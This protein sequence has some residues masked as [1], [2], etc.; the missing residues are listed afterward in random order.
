[1]HD[2]SFITN[3]K[4]WVIKIG[5]ALLAQPQV[6]I[7]QAMITHLSDQI[8][9]LKQSGID[10]VLVSS[11]SIAQGMRKLNL[12]KRPKHVHQLQA[13]AAAGQMGL[14]HAYE[15][16]FKP[17]DMVCAQILL[18]HGD[19]ENRMRYLN[20]R[21]TLQTLLQMNAIPIVNENDTIVTDEVRGDNDTLAALVSNLIEANVLVVLTDQEGL[22]DADPRQN[23]AAQQIFIAD[24]GD[25]ALEKMAGGAGELGTGGMLTKLQAAQKAARSGTV[26]IIANGRTNDVLHSIQQQQQI[27]TW[28]FPKARKIKARKQWIAGQARRNCSIVV[29]SGAVIVLQNE[30]RSLLPIG[31][32]SIEGEFTRGDIILITDENG[33][34]IARG[35]VNYDAFEARKIIGQPSHKITQILGYADDPEMI[36]RDNLVVY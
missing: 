4:V 33:Q 24:A 7:N 32:K 3:A 9:S 23:E 10:V 18:T 31:V 1:M 5:S 16:A 8:A 11:G 17:H 29:D 28:L 15:Q 22:Y 35:L 2:K 34:D 6:G 27:G 26:T 19:L 20:A 30:G 12:S 25:P 36:H 21:R 14:V 13:A